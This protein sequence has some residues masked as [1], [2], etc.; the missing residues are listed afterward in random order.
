MFLLLILTCLCSQILFAQTVS[1]T[2]TEDKQAAED[3]QAEFR[4]AAAEI[5][6]ETSAMIPSLASP[7]NRL[8]YTIKIA[9]LIWTL[10]ETQSRAMFQYAT[11]E[12]KR[13]IVQTDAAMNRMTNQPELE[14]E[15]AGSFGEIRNSSN[16]IFQTR[17]M[18]ISTLANHDAEFAS[19]VLTETGGIISNPEL[20]KRFEQS[21]AGLKTMIAGKIAQQDAGKAL[22]AGRER[23]SKG[24]SYDVTTLLQQIYNKDQTKGI[25]FGKEV[26]DKV[27]S[28]KNSASSAILLSLLRQGTSNSQTI[29]K[30]KSA[31]KKPLFDDLTMRDLAGLLADSMIGGSSRRVSTQ[32]MTYIE[33]YA[34]QKAA[35]VQK[36]VAAQTNQN[37]SRRTAITGGRGNGI[38]SSQTSSWQKINEARSNAQKEITKSFQGLQAQNLSNEDKIKLINETRAKIIA[39][40]NNSFRTSNLIALS[41]QAKQAGQDELAAVL[42]ADA[43]RYVNLQPKERNDFM[44]NRNLANA[45]TSV[46][47]EKSFAILEN[48]IFRLNDIIESF[49]KVGEFSGNSRMVENGEMIMSGASRQ[50]TSYLAINGNN[51]QDLA[52]ADLKRLKNLGDKFSRPEFRIETRLTIAQMLLNPLFVQTNQNMR[53]QNFNRAF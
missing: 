5:L 9:D 49:V 48:M 14:W 39:V 7:E 52:S 38:G 35:L 41:R 45:Y 26:V 16:R 2:A 50:F 44:E 29:A 34:P 1:E 27:K 51:L 12:L 22:E 8:G 17:S 43:E 18:L 10:D 40:N 19:R 33:Q 47:A 3:K 30:D 31:D 13:E 11:D 20:M 15:N 32:A 42:L 25:A 37:N 28:T 21:D 4:E 46:D 23:L 24:V 53:M 6:S 36:A